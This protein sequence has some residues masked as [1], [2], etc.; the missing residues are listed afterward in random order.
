MLDGMT[1][2]SC[3]A[4]ASRLR[5]IRRDLV[6]H[7]ATDSTERPQ[8]TTSGFPLLSAN[9]LNNNSDRAA[10]QKSDPA[11]LHLQFTIE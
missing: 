10:V 9:L 11:D 2:L 8:H 5:Q 1:G 7:P 6:C 3:E 4:I